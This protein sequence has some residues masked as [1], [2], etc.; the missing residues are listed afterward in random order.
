MFYP[1]T[2]ANILT[3]SVSCPTKTKHSHQ[4]SRAY[5][6]PPPDT[7]PPPSSHTPSTIAA[8]PLTPL[9]TFRP[10]PIETESAEPAPRRPSAARAA[11]LGSGVR[12][13]SLL[14]RSREDP[15]VSGRQTGWRQLGWLHWKATVV[16]W[17]ACHSSQPASQSSPSVPRR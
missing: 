11:P 6:W 8:P 9:S 13:R 14:G 12:R 3:A 4:P 7:A 5:R 1:L 15:A 10:F 2:S 17:S 16:S